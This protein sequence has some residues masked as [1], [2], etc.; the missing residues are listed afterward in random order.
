MD[1]V[2]ESE[3]LLPMPPG[4]QSEF[5]TMPPPVI[6]ELMSGKINLPIRN[7]T[8]DANP[9]VNASKFVSVAVK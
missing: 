5:V 7:L 1:S 4:S 3:S 9:Q 8:E 6:L 2:K